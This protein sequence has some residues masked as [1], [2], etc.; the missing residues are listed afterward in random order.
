MLGTLVE[1][2]PKRVRRRL[3]AVVSVWTHIVVIAAAT[4]AARTVG[5]EPEPVQRI[6]WHPPTAAL[7]ECTNC[8][9]GSRGGPRGGI[10]RNIPPLPGSPV[11]DFTL[12][13]PETAGPRAPGPLISTTEWRGGFSDRSSGTGPTVPRREG[14]DR[15]VV[16][17]P[18]NPEPRYPTMLRSAGIQGSVFARFVVDTT[19]RVRMETVSIDASDHA[20]F[21][22]AVIEALRRSRYT[23]AELR[24]RKVPQLVV[25]PFVFVMRP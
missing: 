25:Q 23:P 3:S 8:F 1:S 2:S 4:S 15:E 20:L 5:G 14:V 16:P 10:R 11:A 13:I 19:G 21:S 12:E 7:P 24:G 9:S 17:L 18:T 22:E 6:A